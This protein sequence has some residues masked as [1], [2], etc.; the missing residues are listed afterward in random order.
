VSS[1]CISIPLL[2]ILGLC[3]YPECGDEMFFWNVNTHLTD[4]NVNV[5]LN[6]IKYFINF[7]Y[8]C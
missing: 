1:V 6:L 5:I 8:N 4:H 7:I 2:F 3:I